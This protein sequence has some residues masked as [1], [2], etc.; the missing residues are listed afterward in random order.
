MRPITVALLSATLVLAA[1]G[2]DDG[3]DPAPGPGATGPA[4]GGSATSGPAGETSLPG[5]DID[6]DAPPSSAPGGPT[7]RVAGLWDASGDGAPASDYVDIAAD[8]LWTRYAVPDVPGNCFEV[9]GPYTLTLELP[10]ADGYSLSSED[11]GITLAVEGRRAD[12]HRRRGRCRDLAPH[13][14]RGHP[15]HA[16]PGRTRPR[17]CAGSPRTGSPRADPVAQLLTRT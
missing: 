1:C 2:S 5:P 16:E 8:G 9:A 12:L 11:R 13:G 3:A 14:Q 15:R 4:A 7:P 17:C 10:E 6:P